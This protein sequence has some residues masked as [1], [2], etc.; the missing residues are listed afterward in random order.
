MLTFQK[1]LRPL[2]SIP[3]PLVI[4][5]LHCK[6]PIAYFSFIRRLS[7]IHNTSQALNVKPLTIEEVQGKLNKAQIFFDQNKLTESIVELN[8][9][10]QSFVSKNA[11]ELA[12]QEL[13]FAFQTIQELAKAHGKNGNFEESITQYLEALKLAEELQADQALET[14][15]IYNGLARSYILQGEYS[16]A[17]KALENAQELIS[18]HAKAGEITSR[19]LENQYLTGVL[20]EKQEE[21]EQ[22]LEF[23]QGLLRKI[24]TAKRRYNGEFNTGL[25]YQ[26]IGDIYAKVDE[27]AKAIGHWNKGL[28]ITLEKYGDD[29]IELISFYEKLAENLFEQGDTKEAIEHTERSLE[30]CNKY[31]EGNHPEIGKHHLMLGLA[32]AEKGEYELALDNY[33]KA[34]LIF[35]SHPQQYQEEMTYTYLA[36][37]EIYVKQEN[38]AEAVKFYQIGLQFAKETLGEEHIKMADYYLFWADLLRN[39]PEKPGETVEYLKKALNIYLNT[40]DVDSNA[41]I[42]LYFD[43]GTTLYKEKEYK[44]AL[45]YL[46]ECKKRAIVN[47]SASSKVLEET[48]NYIALVYYQQENFD[49]SIAYFQKAL[50]VCG[51]YG[52]QKD[53]DIYYRNIGLAYDS[54]GMLEK[55]IEYFEKA[56]ELAVKNFGKRGKITRDYYEIVLE[57]L[58]RAERMED[59]EKVRAKFDFE[60]NQP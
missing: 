49:E 30:L 53:L 39:N 24:Q 28:E 35:P 29:S 3:R 38:E 15:D 56:L 31:Y 4:S 32:Y 7:E 59:L 50:D 22:A 33:Q 42:D 25:I 6:Q 13:N 48:Y 2:G 54:K 19:Y 8:Q 21:N 27:D 34:L 10:I 18:Q 20:F 1:L 43:L 37:A 5:S 23:L 57:R 9:I 58:A 51:K 55:A 60:F 26:K 11:S 17:E 12:P 40:E 52:D 36:I 14:A 46:E 41:L 44:E 47:P 16:E 45:K